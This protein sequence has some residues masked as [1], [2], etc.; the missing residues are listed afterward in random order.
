MKFLHSPIVLLK[1]IM[2]APATVSQIDAYQIRGSAWYMSEE[3]K[4][5]YQKATTTTAKMRFFQSYLNEIKAVGTERTITA[6]TAYVITCCVDGTALPFS[7]FPDIL[8]PTK[9]PLVKII[10]EK[11]FSY[12]KRA[13]CGVEMLN[14]L[15]GGKRSEVSEWYYPQNRPYE[16]LEVCSNNQRPS[17]M[18]KLQRCII[19]AF[20]CLEGQTMSPYLYDIVSSSKLENNQQGGEL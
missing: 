18:Y 4:A 9:N 7:S 15:L 20:N 10:K 2:S 3:G 11:G 5:A 17:D 1:L 16:R 14:A 6:L 12:N 8:D 19:G 13:E